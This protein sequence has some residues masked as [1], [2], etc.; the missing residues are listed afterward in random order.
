[1]LKLNARDLVKRAQQLADLE[2]SD[3]ISWNENMML[4]NEAYQKVYQELIEHDDK[5][6]LKPV[7]LEGGVAS[8]NE[9]RF[10]L[11]ADFY[12]LYALNNARTNRCVVCNSINDPINT[13]GYTIEN[14][15]I[16]IQG[17]HEDLVMRYYPNPLTITLKAPDIDLTLDSLFDVTENRCDVYDTKMAFIRT[18]SPASLRVVDIVSG[19]TYFSVLVN[20]V[21]NIT[22][23]IAC[24]NGVLVF[25]DPADYKF[26]PYHG[27]STPTNYYAAILDK[28]KNAW[29]YDY[30]NHV[31]KLPDEYG[32][33]I[34]SVDFSD[35]SHN[36]LSTP[37]VIGYMDDGFIYYLSSENSSRLYAYSVE[38]DE[39]SFIKELKV[40]DTVHLNYIFQDFYITRNKLLWTLDNERLDSGL[41][42]INKV[43]YNTGYGYLLKNGKQRGI[44]E[45][46]EID[47]PNNLF[48]QFLS[49]Q[50]AISYKAKQN[51][52]AAGLIALYQQAEEQLLKAVRRDEYGFTR[53]QNV[54]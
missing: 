24:K 41:V 53:I 28:E 19:E 15:Q 30:A 23:I 50:L 46:T 52:D 9:V 18:S 26:Y 20:N 37:G 27:N 33:E 22:K 10:D 51:Q 25:W 45:D 49:Y 8:D 21:A 31:L 32:T 39:G 13:S 36:P 35:T 12:Q 16:V 43:D 54:Y 4:L 40:S 38:N 42:G 48:I 34:D 17:I 11:P 14:N 5:T 2:N 47:Y 6:Y 7:T 1:M 29:L 44:F 3:F